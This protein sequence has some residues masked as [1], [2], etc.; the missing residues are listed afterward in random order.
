[1]AFVTV[2]QGK[3]HAILKQNPIS[4]LMPSI[5]TWQVLNPSLFQPYSLLLSSMYCN[6]SMKQIKQP[7]HSIYKYGYVYLFFLGINT[8][9]I[10]SLEIS[11]AVLNL[12]FS[13]ITT[14]HIFI[15]MK[16]NYIHH[17]YSISYHLFVQI[18]CI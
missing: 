5:L 16:R 4:C 8:K 3:L 2:V 9:K 13:C 7:F 11:M 6:T 12:L 15:C 10:L 18:E 14:D 17:N 1:M